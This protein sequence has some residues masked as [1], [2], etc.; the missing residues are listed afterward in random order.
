MLVG[1]RV[2]ATIISKNTTRTP[3]PIMLPRR[4]CLFICIN[5]YVT[6][7]RYKTECLSRTTTVEFPSIRLMIFSPGRPAPYGLRI[8][9]IRTSKLTLEIGLSV[10]QHIEMNESEPP[11]RI[12]Q[13]IPVLQ[14]QRFAEKKQQH[15]EIHRIAHVA[16]EASDNQFFWMVN[17]RRNAAPARG[18][19]PNTAQVDGG[20]QSKRNQRR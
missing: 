3:R 19:L 13:K 9:L 16:I 1:W 4:C 2:I 20:S 10:K 14:K 15:T 6:T 7:W 8:F 18:K 12:Q 17:R 11:Q 5:A